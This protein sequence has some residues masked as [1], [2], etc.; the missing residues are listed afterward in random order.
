MS[1]H[2]I[3]RIGFVG[4]GGNTR[5][6]HLPGFQEI[7]G[8]ELVAVANRSPE[9]SRRVAEEYGIGRIA[10]SWQ[11]LVA[12]PDVDAICIGTWPNLHA[13]VTIAALAAG[14][15]VLCEARMAANL[16]EAR[17]MRAAAEARPEL[18]AQ[19]VPAPFSLDFDAMIREILRSGELGRLLEVRVTH[20]TGSQA[21]GDELLSWRQETELSGVN[22]MSL[23]ILHE[24][25]ERWL[26]D[27][28][29]WL[30]ADAEVSH[31]LRRRSSDAVA[32][33]VE[34]PDSLSV[35]GR[36]A[37]SGARLIY[38][39][40]AVESGESR[41]EFRINGSQGALRFD[42]AEGLLYR[43]EAGQTTERSVFPRNPVGWRVEADFV[44]SIRD[45]KPVEL[46]SFDQ[47][48]RYMKFTEMVDV[49][50]RNQARRVEWA[51]FRG[52]GA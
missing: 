27:E 48:E 49:S 50:W 20:T 41:L 32:E 12:A 33:R 23:G 37:R 7:E 35:L 52:R 34:I 30:L 43:A 1:C 2:E 28:P 3:L 6:R 19:I 31:P 44:A 29:E 13:Q 22:V 14:K 5:L 26:D 36:F 40:S 47:G 9:S 46:T 10:D 39:V 8:V 51:E 18:V 42:G 16:A 11:D 45:G 15:H 24:T 4:A 38:H 17:A 25:V 21:T